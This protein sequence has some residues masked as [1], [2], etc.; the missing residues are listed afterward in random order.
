MDF[1]VSLFEGCRR[2][3][4]KTRTTMTVQ[5]LYVV[6]PPNYVRYNSG[7]QRTTKEEEEFG[8]KKIQKKR[9]TQ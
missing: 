6:K 5:R 7:R 9:H 4:V 2:L 8:E 1:L 3:H